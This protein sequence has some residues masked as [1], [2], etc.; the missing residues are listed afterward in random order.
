MGR[1]RVLGKLARWG[2][3]LLALLPMVALVPG[4]ILDRSHEGLLRVSLFPVALALL[5]HFTWTCLRNSTLAASV[6]TVLALAIGLGLAR[7]I[8]GWRFW[9]RGIARSLI[10]A[11]VVV[12]PLF[13]ALGLR[14]LL[15]DGED[16]VAPESA[17]LSMRWLALVVSALT[18][19]VPL[20]VLA[21][22]GALNR[23][24]STW[25]LAARASGESPGRIWWTLT[26]PLIRPAAAR[27][28]SAVFAIALFDPGAP[29]ILG[30]RQTLGFQ[31]ADA[32]LGDEAPTRA[33]ILALL[34]CG[35]AFAVRSA[36]LWWGHGITPSF[37]ANGGVRT[38]RAS[39]PRALVYCLFLASWCVVTWAPVLG[40]VQLAESH[41]RELGSPTSKLADSFPRG[42]LEAAAIWP[43][44]LQSAL[45]G[46]AV[47]TV[48]LLL[49]WL[50]GFRGSRRKSV[51]TFWARLESLPPVA[52]AVGFLTLPWLLD[53]CG[54]TLR[55]R[56]G[57]GIVSPV[58]FGL[59]R[60]LDPYRAPGVA[61][62]LALA[63]L[64]LT[65]PMRVAR[66][67]RRECR[68]V[69]VDAAVT[70]GASRRTAL[71][72]VI[73]PLVG[74]QLLRAWVLTATLAMCSVGPA[75]ILV[76]R[77]E[78]QTIGPSVLF[79]ADAPGQG[80]RAAVLALIGGGCSLA[81]LAWAARGNLL[82]LGREGGFV[83]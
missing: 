47:A 19:G 74:S 31:I 65:F 58:C 35:L 81:A 52:L 40:L 8:A 64:R 18:L 3:A 12:P 78:R 20:V 53:G 55:F 45:L 70:L 34:G 54:Q 80:S 75:L 37:H 11:M 73:G 30:L 67:A 69:L 41:T 39:W 14:H 83:D 5:D 6:T 79:A 7:A 2:L 25:E 15:L 66:R 23:V 26:W 62:A 16:P 9:G 49:A 82:E 72:T 76:P 17:W 56:A 1:P 28:A 36:F 43:V 48:D 38:R 4:A 51:S 61:L 42:S 77:S 22:H 21:V 59:A 13:S 46:G 29:M 68:A 10:C 57:G 50:W 71:L 33:A 27:V 44:L 63:T 32:A 24:D 60:L